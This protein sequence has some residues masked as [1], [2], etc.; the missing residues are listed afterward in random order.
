MVRI[1]N[2]PDEGDTTADTVSSS[3]SATTT[4]SS[5]TTATIA[6]SKRSRPKSSLD[7]K[8]NMEHKGKLIVERDGAKDDADST[9]KSGQQQQSSSSTNNIIMGMNPTRARGSSGFI[10]PKPKFTTLTE[11]FNSGL[12]DEEMMELIYNDPVLSA[13]FGESQREY[14][15][16]QQESAFMSQQQPSQSPAPRGAGG[17]RRAPTT[18]GGPS[19]SSYKKSTPIKSSKDR[20][21]L[22][23]EDGIPYMQWAVLVV[24]FL[25]SLYQNDWV[26]VSF[27][28]KPSIE[29]YYAG[30][31]RSTGAINILTH[32]RNQLV[33]KDGLI[34]SIGIKTSLSVE[35]CHVDILGRLHRVHNEIR[36]SLRRR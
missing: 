26:K 30:M 12:T 15:K 25:F 1:Q 23:K 32:D 13:K 24:V 17:N 10:P 14:Q 6:G 28:N 9:G 29:G 7:F 11:V 4:T 8:V 34:E 16:K 31:N 20:V 22:L 21:E 5:A 19:S 2:P 27:K 3:E 33:G 36:Q 35:K 18:T